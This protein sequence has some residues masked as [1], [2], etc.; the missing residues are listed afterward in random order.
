MSKCIQLT[1]LGSGVMAIAELYLEDAPRTTAAMLKMLATPYEAKMLHGIF[2]GR[3]ITIEPP[4]ANRLFDPEAIPPENTTA[5]PVTGDLL[6]K[7]FP[8]RAVR[9][10]PMGLWDVMFIYGP[11]AILKNPLGIYAS[12]LW[13]HVIEN[14]EAFTE[15]CSNVRVDGAKTIRL[16]LLDL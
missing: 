11:E 7:Y 9:G 5:Y 8:P 3:K 1:V 10:M 13:G 12:N 16:Q 15:E 4:L 2:E 6:W 14:L